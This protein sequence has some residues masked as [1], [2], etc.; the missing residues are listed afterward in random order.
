M[1]RSLETSETCSNMV[2]GL[3]GGDEPLEPLVVDLGA[4]RGRR[5]LPGPGTQMGRQV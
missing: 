4:P 5:I 3:H 2:L 1:A